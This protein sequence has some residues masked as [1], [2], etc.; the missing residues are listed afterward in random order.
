M[1]KGTFV[2]F[3]PAIRRMLVV[4]GAID[5]EMRLKQFLHFQASIQHQA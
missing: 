3:Y 4:V 5:P 2:V 1:S